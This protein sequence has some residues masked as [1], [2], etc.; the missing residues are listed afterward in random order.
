M[1]RILLAAFAIFVLSG[2]CVPL[3]MLNRQAEKG[4]AIEK[5]RL[6]SARSV[7]LYPS[8]LGFR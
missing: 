8:H 6:P 3:A 1:L 7:P 5:T 2:G 4:A